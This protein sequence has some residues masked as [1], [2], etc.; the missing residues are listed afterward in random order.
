MPSTAAPS[1]CLGGN[2]QIHAAG[3]RENIDSNPLLPLPDAQAAV[4][5]ALKD[6]LVTSAAARIQT[7]GLATDREG[8]FPV[9]IIGIDPQAELPV[10]LVAEHISAGRFLAPDDAELDP[11][12]PRPR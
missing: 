11:D 5:T 3:Y 1:A 4:Q 8:A 9:G 10:S 6:P 7:G 12:R 2:I